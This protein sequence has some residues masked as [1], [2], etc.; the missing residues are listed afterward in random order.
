MVATLGSVHVLCELSERSVAVMV[1]SLVQCDRDQAV[2]ESAL[3]EFG[4]N[5]VVAAVG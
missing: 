1:D 4:G 5:P 2:D 3:L